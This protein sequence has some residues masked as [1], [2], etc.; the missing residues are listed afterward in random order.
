MK[1]RQMRL[2]GCDWILIDTIKGSVHQRAL[3]CAALIQFGQNFSSVPIC[4]DA[5]EIPS[6]FHYM[7]QLCTAESIVRPW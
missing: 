6:R 4:F 1:M 3:F 2:A 7:Y 5:L